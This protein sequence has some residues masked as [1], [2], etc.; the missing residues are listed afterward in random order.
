MTLKSAT[1]LASLYGCPR[2]QTLDTLL[3]PYKDN[4]ADLSVGGRTVASQLLGDS[5][6]FGRAELGRGEVSGLTHPGVHSAAPIRSWEI[7]Y[8][9]PFGRA[10]VC[11]VT[12]P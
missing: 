5:N 3:H 8:T 9:N 12:P 7:V 6:L 4:P 1:T 10:E 2:L 11:K